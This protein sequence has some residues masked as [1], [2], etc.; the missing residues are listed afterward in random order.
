MPAGQSPGWFPRC[1]GRF[2]V[3]RSVQA[4][5][6]GP[7]IQY[8]AFGLEAAGVEAFGVIDAAFA[9]AFVGPAVQVDRQVDD[10]FL[11]LEELVAFP[12]TGGFRFLDGVRG[13]GGGGRFLGLGDVHG[14]DPSGGCEVRANVMSRAFCPV[15]DGVF[16]WY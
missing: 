13:P 1:R 16:T 8:P 5:V 4:D 3:S 6:F 7:L 14:R 12:L 2:P 9:A 10:F 15:H 11:F